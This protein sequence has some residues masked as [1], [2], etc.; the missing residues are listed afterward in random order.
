MC[1]SEGRLYTA[2]D[3]TLY[4]YSMSDYTFP[5]CTYQLG[6]HC[7]SGIITNSHLYLGGGKG[8]LHVFELTISLTQELNSVNLINTIQSVLKILRV[9]Y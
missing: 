2:A 3:E 4:V 1:L 5:I 9:G 6:G 7:E 8:K